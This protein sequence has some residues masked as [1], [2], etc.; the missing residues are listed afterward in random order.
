MQ[1]IFN[2]I[3]TL[4]FIFFGVIWSKKTSI[5][6]FMKLIC[7]VLSFIGLLLIFGHMGYVIKN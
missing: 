7:I 1:L 4:L 6:V 3:A 2:I 5:D